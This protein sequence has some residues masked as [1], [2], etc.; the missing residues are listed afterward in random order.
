MCFLSTIEDGE[1]EH[2][3]DELVSGSRDKKK[4]FELSRTSVPPDP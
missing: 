3:L 4:S 1:E 2:L